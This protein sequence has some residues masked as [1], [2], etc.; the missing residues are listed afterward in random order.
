MT[1]G[2]RLWSYNIPNCKNRGIPFETLTWNI[3][4]HHDYLILYLT[5]NYPQ[6]GLG[7]SKP[8]HEN[9]L[10][11]LM[12]GFTALILLFL[13]FGVVTIYD[14][15]KVSR[16]SLAI[17]NHP[18]VVS[19]AALQANVSIAKMHRS[20]KD[21]VL[22]HSL[23]RIQQSI[24]IVNDEE[25]RVHRQLDIV[26]NNILGEEGKTLEN[27]A[28]KLFDAWRPIRNEVIGLVHNDQIE[29]AANITIGKGADHVALLEEKMLGL[30]NYAR[31]KASE[32]TRE[33]EK[34]HS[35]LN[36]ITISFLIVGI[37]ISLLVAYWSI[38]QT[39]FAQ[40]NINRSESR[41]RTLFNSI[42]DAILV[43]D[44]NRT[45][46]DC[47]P[48]LLDLF[49]YSKEEVLGKQTLS[50]YKNEEEFKQMGVAIKDHIGDPEFLYTVNYKKKDCSVFP[51]ET[52][53]F[54]LLDD[55]GRTTGFIGLIR[56]ITERELA[57]EQQD[58]LIAD[59]QKTLSEVKTLRGFLP[60]CSHCKNVRDDKGYWNQIEAY[61]E[62]HSE[63]EFSHSIC[64]ECA[65]KY[66]PE[67]DLYDDKDA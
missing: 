54:Y 22:F 37:L 19:N 4:N 44:T 60:I 57:Q 14:I 38:N 31:N 10:Q 62:D 42:R 53:V 32:F 29:N 58:H 17:Y 13:L 15:Q 40:Q 63:T 43:A 51:G 12:L 48:A 5:L 56:N 59:L 30:T 16:L 27:E 52:N 11:G 7:M 1:S 66:F 67:M 28:R 61:I 41:Y 39:K 9:N 6:R 25:E 50:I 64:P 65:K 46:I 36:V 8:R 34:V 18:L 45:I 35:R 49:G 26:K 21:V 2:Q 20:M 55:E 24:E 23:S 3:F 33:S 47:N